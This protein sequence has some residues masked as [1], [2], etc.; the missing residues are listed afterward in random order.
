MAFH[1]Q[2]QFGSSASY[3]TKGR[4]AS[5]AVTHRTHVF[6]EPQDFGLPEVNYKGKPTWIALVAAGIRWKTANL[7]GTPPMPRHRYASRTEVS[8]VRS[9]LRP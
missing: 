4:L 8:K 1:R 3:G 9:D 7:D 6:A 2:H 5:G